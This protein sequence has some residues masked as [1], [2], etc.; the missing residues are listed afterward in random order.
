MVGKVPNIHT[1]KAAFVPIE[2]KDVGVS[3][4]VLDE[5]VVAAL[6]LVAVQILVMVTK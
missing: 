2:Q 1:C 3:I 6:V 4:V 5:E